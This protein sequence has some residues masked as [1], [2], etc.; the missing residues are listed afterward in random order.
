[1]TFFGLRC[2][3]VSAIL[4]CVLVRMNAVCVVRCVLSR[5]LYLFV[6]SRGCPRARQYD[7]VDASG[8]LECFFLC[9][10]LLIAI[11]L[12]SGRLSANCFVWCALSRECCLVFFFFSSRCYPWTKP[13]RCCGHLCRGLVSQSFCSSVCYRAV[14]FFY[15]SS[16]PAKKSKKFVDVKPLE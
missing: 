2:A 12:R 13:A 10:T 9:A 3:L 7:V 16:S 6:S 5:E 11:F 8:V 1:M 4:L 15:I 14:I